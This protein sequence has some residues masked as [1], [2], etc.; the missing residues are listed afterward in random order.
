MNCKSE[1]NI[2]LKNG[3]IPILRGIPSFDKKTTKAFVEN[4]EFQPPFNDQSSYNMSTSTQTQPTSKG[5]VHFDIKG[6]SKQGWA[7]TQWNRRKNITIDYR[8]VDG[9]LTNFT[10]LLNI[11]DA[12]LQDF[13]QE[14]GGDII[15]TRSSGEKLNHEIEIFDQTANST[16]AHLV[17][18]V[19]VDLSNF[20][21][22]QISMYFGNKTVIN[23]EKPESVW[24]EDYIS[25]WHLGENGNGSINE[26][27][28]STSNNNDGQGGG[29]IPEQTPIQVPGQI[30]MA[31]LFDGLD[32]LIQI[33]S[34][35]SLSQPMEEITIGGW[36]YSLDGTLGGSIISSAN[37]F[38][39]DFFNNEIW[40]LLSGTENN[41]WQTSQFAEFDWHHYVFTYDGMVNLLY[42][43]GE[44][45][46]GA[47]NQG[48]IQ[49]TE[50]LYIGWN[51]WISHFT[52]GL[53]DEVRI[54]NISR[55][56]EWIMTQ[57]YNQYDPESFYSIGPMEIYD[58]EPPIIND[59]GVEDLGD[60]SPQFWANLTDKKSSVDFVTL[61]LN[62]T[63]YNMTFDTEINLWIYQPSNV[64]F[65]DTYFY[66]ISN[67]SD[68]WRNYL[69][70]PSP[71]KIVTFNYDS[72]HPNVLNWE[73][74]PDEGEY[75][76]FKANVSDS[77]GEIDVVIVNVTKG[78]VSQGPRWA[79][80]QRDNSKYINDTI[81]LDFG[82]FK[83]VIIV[84]DTAGNSFTSIEHQGIVPITNHA[85]IVENITLSCDPSIPLL[86]V[87]SNNTLYL[88]Y[89]FYDQ[90]NDSEAGTEIRWFR[91]GVL[92]GAYNDKI[93]VP[94]TALVKGDNW[95]ATIRPKDGL[96]FGNT[97]SSDTI[98]IQNTAPTASGITITLNPTTID[99]IEASWIPADYDGDNPN[100]YFN[101]TILHWFKWNGSVWEL[102]SSLSNSTT[103]GSGN[104]TKND[105]WYYTVKIFDGED[106]SIEYSSSNSTVV[107]SKPVVINPVFN[108]SS[109]V[110]SSLPFEITYIYSDMD[111]DLENTGKRIIYWYINGTYNST[112]TNFTII[113]SIYTHEGDLW[114]YKICVHDGDEYSINYTSSLLGIGE[115][116]NTP[117]TV[118]SYNL[119]ELPTT[120][121][122]LIASYTYYDDDGHFQVDKE[123]HWFKNGI[124]QPELDDL[125]VVVS[126]LTSKHEIWNYTLRV[127]DGLNWSI[128]YNSSIVVILNSLPE[129]SDLT[130]T[131]YPTTVDD[132]IISWDY[133]DNDNDP[134]SPNYLI[135]W[136]INGVYNTTYDNY[137]SI[138][139][140]F[141]NKG[142]KWNYTLRVFDGENYSIQ[143][144]SSTAIIT[145]TLPTAINVSLND[146]PLT[147]DNLTVNYIYYDADGD[148]ESSSWRIRWYKNNEFQ[149]ELNDTKIVNFENTTKNE[150][151]YYKIQIFDG[152]NYSNYYFST[153]RIIQNTPPELSNLSITP[154]PT[155][156]TIL[157]A[158][159]EFHD[160]DGD[161]ESIIRIIYW[162]KDGIHQPSLD[163]SIVVPSSYTSKG[164]VW[165]YTVKAF[166]GTDFSIQFNSTTTSIINLAPTAT[167][168]SLTD[169]PTTSDDL[170]ANW[171]F[172]D[173]DNDFE[174]NNP[175]MNWYK[176]DELQ[177]NFNNLTIIPSTAT[178]KGET[179]YYTVRVYDGT[180][181]SIQYSS[182]LTVITNSAPMVNN[183]Q[184][185]NSIC[186]DFQ[187][188]DVNLNIAYNFVD[189]DNDKDF[190]LIRWY[191]NGSYQP[192]FEGMKWVSANNTNP[193]EIWSIEILPFDGSDYG[194]KIGRIIVIESRPT[195]NNFDYESLDDLE[196]HYL[197]QVNVTDPRNPLKNYYEVVYEIY[198]NE[199]ILMPENLAK[200]NEITNLW[201][202]DFQLENYSYI[203]SSIDIVVTATTVVYYSN[204]YYDI[205]ISRNFSLVL[206]DVAPPRILNMYYE[207]DDENQPTN[208][209][210]FVEIQEFGSGVFNVTL[211]YR[212]EIINETDGGNGA[213]EIQWYQVPMVFQYENISRNSKLFSVTVDFSPDSDTT[214]FYRIQAA[215][216]Q[217]NVNSENTP[218]N[219]IFRPII[220]QSTFELSDLIPLLV[221]VGA[222][223][224]F[225]ITAIL[226][227]RK[228]HQTRLLTRKRKK[229]E[230]MDRISDILSLRVIICRNK[231]GVAFFTD[232]YAGYGQD[233]D[234]IAGITSAM[235]S[236]VSEIA[237]R[238][239]NSGEYD[240]LER[241]GFS[242]LS[243]H[244]KYTTIS[245]VSE[246]KLSLYLKMKMQKL[247]YKIESRFTQEELEGLITPQLVK[248]VEKIVL[249]I[250]PIRLLRPL[251]FDQSL[252]KA[253]IKQFTK[254]ERKMSELISEIPSFIDG[255]HAFYAINFISS[256]TLNG[257]PLIEAFN[258]LEHCH[259]SGIMRNLSEEEL[260]FLDSTTSYQENT[261]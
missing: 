236:M 242:I 250:L 57:Y 189:L 103:V 210:F 171:I 91:N 127:Y 208:I 205:Q 76:T 73:Y 143:Y 246:E 150:I 87:H 35:T 34:S 212:Y 145:N 153:S 42:I 31:Q 83:F 84:N 213:Q 162:Y 63:S 124:L 244:G 86:P 5:I 53:I 147:N 65:A 149:P 158:S 185:Q 90:E 139:S 163:N 20:Q 115:T 28:D 110:S 102:Q 203:G 100:D 248:D 56:P 247:G 23:Q 71:P 165:Y 1:D 152:E 96:D 41:P 186:P 14:D 206:E 80:M 217:G 239:I 27:K 37:D 129:A 168:L 231:C 77:W 22:N 183:F 118:T 68:I 15:F 190:S 113:D 256:L 85:P 13:A 155:T 177:S 89:D 261:V 202:L 29:G 211:F 240:I 245:M 82:L 142:E 237:E 188:E 214:I 255:Q 98:T 54:S 193:G 135:N 64:V 179:W 121:D 131:S 221:L 132:L 197:F 70:L 79:V 232:S 133:T 43:D 137:T 252:F 175:I 157:E 128:Q 235:S 258:F 7:D 170:S 154:N 141:T 146:N 169:S 125:T 114:Q 126:S 39:F 50:P 36:V 46:S 194:T 45:R 38:G 198:I 51:N 21:E 93:V 122:N 19:Q 173:L 107:N 69:S 48:T 81:I 134:E 44:L 259:N 106:Y 238:N 253:N 72:V 222:L 201:E 216:Y 230:I 59:F 3:P 49:N 164:E 191:V 218:F 219:F 17:A 101:F 62:Q 119:T 47:S 111:D 75:G 117:P 209:T 136:Y 249:E 215:D 251:T 58:E 18:W 180:D 16:H 148:P 4:N 243:Y 74:F 24:N 174:D 226:L 151:W 144:N 160:D 61:K 116:I 204:M 159:W 9:D 254:N 220:N 33:P 233:E 10:L 12:D 92:Q 166:D 156:L 97:T 199:S 140:N 109:S 120:A 104:T 184:I 192:Q 224:A 200:K 234:M 95:N 88:L 182:P 8:K 161:Y 105:T 99:D 112:F 94:N 26:Y 60:G 40:I 108:V 25:V 78:K 167:D 67:A 66:E 138:S 11:F 176:N 181:Y 227:A 130:L 225:L 6:P 55:S 257:I 178:S 223:P 196:G 241:E 260:S 228:Y 172:I 207:I 123:I 32:N 195:I 2:S 229:K 52:K 187:V 30:G